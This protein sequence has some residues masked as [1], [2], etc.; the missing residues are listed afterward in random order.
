MDE[1]AKNKGRLPRGRA[2]LVAGLLV[3]GAALA[4]ALGL[5]TSSVT[6]AQSQ[7]APRNTA[8]PTIS[9]TAAQ[10]ETLTANV[11]TWTGDQPI[12]FTFQ[13]L[14]CNAGGG[15]CVAIPNADDQTYAVVQ[16]DVDNTLRARVTARNNQG[17][18][19]ATTVQTAKV[20]GPVGPAGAVRLPNG[21]ISIPVTSV[22]ATERLIVDRVEFT[23]N[24]IRSRTEP[25]QV[26]IKVEDT[27]NYVVRDALVFVRS[28]PQ[29][30]SVPPRSRTGQD[31]W[32]TYTMAPEPDFPAIRNAYNV[33][34]FVKAYRQGD[35][36]L[37]GVAGYRLVQVAMAK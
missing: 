36:P 17:T 10:N 29:V 23:P 37:G 25:I 6:A 3:A 30:T 20:T 27:R 13:W 22:P 8:P 5:G 9:G 31:G 11:G 32:I 28:T 21:E 2:L 26:R 19:T 1:A 16:A 7:Y 33:Q 24:P 34:F 14:R 35:N 15:N 4:A 12:V 18:Q